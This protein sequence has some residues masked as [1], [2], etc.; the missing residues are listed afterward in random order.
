MGECKTGHPA[1]KCSE[2]AFRAAMTDVREAAPIHGRG[3]LWGH[4][5]VCRSTC[6][7]RAPLRASQGARP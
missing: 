4:C 2:A 6:M 1:A 5:P 3:G 7:Y